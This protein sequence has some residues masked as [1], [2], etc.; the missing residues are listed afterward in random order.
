MVLSAFDQGWYRSACE[1]V[2]LRHSNAD[3]SDTGYEAVSCNVFYI[4]KMPS[5]S[6]I[7]ILLLPNEPVSYRRA[8]AADS[9]HGAEGQELINL[10]C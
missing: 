7:S 3:P 6:I 4:Y 9:I 8:V 5:K 1:D 10:I 2:V